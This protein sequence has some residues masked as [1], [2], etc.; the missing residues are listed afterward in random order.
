MPLY[1]QI[2]DA[3]RRQIESGE[4]S[5]GALVPSEREI[6]ERYGV[7]RMTARQSLRSLRHD[8]LVYHERGIGTFAS[9][10]KVDVHTRNLVGFSEEM[11]QLG[12]KPSSQVLLLQREA[13]SRE[14]ADSL[15]IETGAEVIYFERLRL[16]DATPM[17]LESN[18][19]AAALCPNLDHFDLTKKSLYEVLEKEYGIRMQRADEVLEA[20]AAGKREANLLSIK[21]GVPV[22][23]VHRVVYSDTNEVVESVRTIYRADRYRATFH[24]TKNEL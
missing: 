21:A 14:I 19:L 13:A 1:A 5:P 16:A 24:L 10:R 11:R 20:V 6:A 7:S 3:L 18:Y 23:A 12:Y 22:L 15:G 4:I 17:A 8:G 2:L 9:K